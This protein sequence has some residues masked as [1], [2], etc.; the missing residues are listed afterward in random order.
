MKHWDSLSVAEQSALYIEE[1]DLELN[2][3]DVGILRYKE[4]TKAQPMSKRASCRSL[5][6]LAA[7][8]LSSAIEEE[9]AKV[10]AGRGMRGGNQWGHVFIYMD[11]RVLASATVMT[12]IDLMHDSSTTTPQKAITNIGRDI[13]QETHFTIL[14]RE[15]PKL[16]AVMQKRIKRWDRRAL[17][18]ALNK[19]EQDCTDR[20]GIKRKRLVGVKLLELAI[21]HSGIF[22][23][24]VVKGRNQHG[25]PTARKDIYLTDEAM[26]T[27]SKMDEHLELMSPRY[28]PMLVPPNEWSNDSNGGYTILSRYHSMVKTSFSAEEGARDHGDIAYKAINA[29]QNTAFKINPIVL[30]TVKEVWDAGG[31]FGIPSPENTPIPPRPDT[32]DD[33][34][35]RVEAEKVY[36]DNARIVGRRIQF[37]KTMATATKFKDRIFYF[38]WQY[39]FRSRLYPIPAFLQ[40]QGPDLARGLLLLGNGKKLGKKGMRWLLIRLANCWGVDKVSFDDRVKFAKNL[41]RDHPDPA[42]FDPLSSEARELWADADEPLQA[43]ATVAEIIAAYAHPKGP[44]HYVS[45]LPVNVDGSNSGLQHFTAMLRDPEGAALVNLTNQPIPSDPYRNV[46]DSVTCKVE[47]DCRTIESG[48]VEGSNIFGSMWSDKPD[49]GTTLMQLP[50]QWLAYEITRKVTKRATMTYPYGVTEQGVR[51]NLIQDGYVDWAD[52]QFAA[53]RYL[54]KKIWECI[55]ENITGAAEAM[56]WLRQCA[57][58]ANKHNTLLTWK[59]PSGFTVRHPYCKLKDQIVNCLGGQTV[60]KSNDFEEGVRASKQRTGLPPNF[61]HSLDATH[62]MMTVAE[63]LK[64]GIEDWVMIHDS[65]GCHA[66]DVDLLRDILRH[67]FVKLYS[68]NVLEEFRLQVI[69]Q[70]GEDPGPPPEQGTFDLNEVYKSEYIFG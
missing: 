14:K 65:F 9:T 2:A 54:G 13:E 62:L 42:H 23:S 8:N 61:V 37:L 60:F 40:P 39:D 34:E 57:T 24:R 63:G 46:S 7:E 64:V 4:N 10:V 44:K 55:R 31:G 27:I 69:G 52:N 22:G 28:E 51:D 12:L 19:I 5:I 36:R 6:G 41:M 38:P 29:L 67:T 3:L 25:R 45:Y 68:G 18:S 15:A 43:L 49:V 17:R 30:A 66:C 58:V 33:R 11:P 1:E 26:E 56:D 53:S 16:K 20:W 21:E 35:W 59:T 50:R 70:T 32:E 48:V 47:E